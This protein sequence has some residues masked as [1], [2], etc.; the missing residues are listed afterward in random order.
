LN[1]G[2]GS[3][4]QGRLLGE[5]RGG[6]VAGKEGPFSLRGRGMGFLRLD[7]KRISLNM[8]EKKKEKRVVRGEQEG[9][10]KKKETTTPRR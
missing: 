9:G 2:G 3:L 4:F 10:K 7:S 6:A 1:R 8:L 5:K